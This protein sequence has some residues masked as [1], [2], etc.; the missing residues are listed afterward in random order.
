MTKGT[1]RLHGSP[2]G[3][4][5]VLI[6]LYLLP[7]G[8]TQLPTR[9]LVSFEIGTS[10][11]GTITA[12]LHGERSS[13]SYSGS[14][15][16]TPSPKSF[17]SQIAS[18]VEIF[19]PRLIMHG[20]NDLKFDCI[21]YSTIHMITG[22]AASLELTYASN[23]WSQ[24]L[25]HYRQCQV[26]ES[27]TT[28]VHPTIPLAASSIA[29]Q[30]WS[31]Q[32]AHQLPNPAFSVPPGYGIV[33]LPSYVVTSLPLVLTFVDPT[34]QGT[35]RISVHGLIYVS[36]DGGELW[37]GPYSLNGLPYPN[38]L[39][40]HSWQSGGEHSIVVKVVWNALWFLEGQSG[41]LSLTTQTS[42]T[43]SVISLVSLRSE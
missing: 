29:N 17:S 31:Q 2:F 22:T 10:Q 30:L 13:S 33:H 11:D 5:A 21:T 38:G 24:L 14:T 35:L 12:S 20:G 7:P 42:S 40:S 32:F 19:I 34:A 41:S 23:L 37:Q 18:L 28:Q 1:S 15:T 27:P 16:K 43:F 39:I 8:I 25:A 4:W 26:I 3:L 6:F 9:H 36:F